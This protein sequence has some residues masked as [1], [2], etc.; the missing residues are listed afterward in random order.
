MLDVMIDLETMSTRSDAS[1]VAIGAVKFDPSAVPGMFDSEYYATIDLQS[2]IDAGMRVDGNTIK[3]WLKQSDEARSALYREPS[4]HQKSTE[5]LQLDVMKALSDFWAWY[6]EES[7]PTWGNGSSFDL[8]ILGNAYLRW[9]T[10]TP[11]KFYHE[12]CFRTLRDE[13]PNV[14]RRKPDLAHHALEDAKAQAYTVQLIQQYKR[15]LKVAYDEVG[16]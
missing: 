12:K 5:K 4:E 15:Q 9:W 14:M 16:G 3:W 6:G 11:W 1:I 10:N 2:C 8:T 7:V 13:F